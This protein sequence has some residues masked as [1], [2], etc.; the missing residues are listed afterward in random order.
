MILLQLLNKKVWQKGIHQ[1]DR[2][3][4]LRFIRINEVNRYLILLRSFFYAATWIFCNRR[5]NCSGRPTVVKSKRNFKSKIGFQNSYL[6]WLWN[7]R[8]RFRTTLL[9]ERFRIFF[10][11]GDGFVLVKQI[12]CKPNMFNYRLAL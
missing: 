2:W 6:M 12:H 9:P 4:M 7:K 1:L 8:E 3:R 11:T 5:R 10:F